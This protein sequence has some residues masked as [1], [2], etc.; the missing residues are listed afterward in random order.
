MEKK[1]T[2]K[3][4]KNREVLRRIL[5]FTRP[6]APFI[7]IS[8]VCAAVSV[9]VSLIVPV[10]C[11][12]AID[13]MIGAGSV[14]FEGVMTIIGGIGIVVAV[15]ALAQWIM[16]V[17][18]NKITFGVS[19]DLRNEAIRKIQTLPLSFLDSHPTG[20]LLSRIT[21]DVDT[22]SDG[23][24]MGF[25]QLFSGVITILGTV[26]FM[27]YVSPLITLVVVV[28]TP[29]SLLVARFIASHTYRYFRQQTV[30]R[31]DQT[32]FINE[33]IE[34]MKASPATHIAISVSRRLPEEIR[35]HLSMK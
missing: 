19:R 22:F 10:F 16:A 17:C 9:A 6:Y 35:L 1:K 30:A 5:L 31:G 34:G 33:M 27:L 3:T 29:M 21:A 4:N 28:L 25:T 26:G 18:N 11:G 23:L 24:L 12:K 7:V 15:A 32:A 20:D 2:K 8:F 13:E 14:R